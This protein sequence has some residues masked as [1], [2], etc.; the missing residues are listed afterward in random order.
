MTKC[1]VKPKR[2]VVFIMVTVINME[3]IVSICVNKYIVIII[4]KMNSSGIIRY[5]DVIN[6]MTF[7]SKVKFTIKGPHSL[8]NK[9]SNSISARYRGLH[10]SYIGHI[11][12]T[13]CGNSD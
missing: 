10:H 4:Q 11:D 5:N 7:F 1:R 2:M 3:D 9:N 8:G 6:D 13:V 12:L